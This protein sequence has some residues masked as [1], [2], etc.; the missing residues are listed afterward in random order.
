MRI[1]ARNCQVKK[2]TNKEA[3]EFLDIYH[4]QKGINAEYSYGLFFEGELVQVETFGKPRIEQQ[5]QIIWHDWELLREC[6][7]SD[8]YIL[9]G[10]SKLLKAFE[11]EVHPL[12]LL[13]YCN[14]TEGFDGHSYKE[15]GFKLESLT[16]DY[17]YEYNGDNIKRYA[18]QKNSNV[19]NQG[20]KE[21]IQ[22]TLEKYGKTYDP[23]LSERE[24]AER[25]GFVRVEG[26]GQQ[27]WSKYYT[28]NLGY[29]YLITN[30]I[31]GKRYIGQHTLIEDGRLKDKKY[32]GSGTALKKAVE[33]YGKRSFKREVLEW[34]LDLEKLTE[35]EYKYID[36][37]KPEY[38]ESLN[39]Y[40][41]AA[42]RPG[43][44][45]RGVKHHSEETK[46][47]ISE[48]N[49]NKVRSDETKEKIAAT[50]RAYYKNNP[51][52][53]ARRKKQGR[54]G[55]ANVSK[56][57]EVRK[58]LSEGAKRRNTVAC[59]NTPESIAKRNKTKKENL[60][61]MTEEERKSKFGHHKNAGRKASEELRKRLA[62]AH[63]G[64]RKGMHWKIIDGHRVWY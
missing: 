25:A 28:N 39:P 62:E 7:K 19:R 8:Y 58:K 55:E 13:S 64:Q 51:M 6:S 17:W 5:N 43:T 63:K 38:N 29:I 41:A 54:K 36:E 61:K 9:G 15:C 24:N 18:M 4:K 3:K 21:E 37:L 46:K 23:N 11:K 57:P 32:F 30:R 56:R 49:K 1:Y 20:K 35:L 10:K 44:K 12:S 48:G 47:K 42:H 26:K 16:K 27:C 50:L 34:V 40:N 33:K 31:N 53:E 52:P 22:K 60:A 45:E 59:M 2:I 14:T